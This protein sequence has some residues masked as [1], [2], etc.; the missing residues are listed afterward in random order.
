MYARTRTNIY[1]HAHNHAHTTA[2]TQKYILLHFSPSVDGIRYNVFCAFYLH[3]VATACLVAK[4]DIEWNL[5][6]NQTFIPK[7]SCTV[8]HHLQC[9]HTLKASLTS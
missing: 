9:P 7:H 1:I 5:N 4:I 6:S 2:V 3:T 8:T